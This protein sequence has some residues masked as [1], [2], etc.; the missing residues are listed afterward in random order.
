MLYT[1]DLYKC[2]IIHII[3]YNITCKI[4]Y[5]IIYDIMALLQFLPPPPFFF[6]IDYDR[7]FHADSEKYKNIAL[8]I[9]G[10]CSNLTSKF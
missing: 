9:N 7:E 6:M 8:K 2:N 10:K 4:T 5:K 3:I 1:K